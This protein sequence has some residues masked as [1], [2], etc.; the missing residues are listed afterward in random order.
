MPG[1][2]CGTRRWSRRG[3]RSGSVRATSSQ[4][5]SWP[6]AVGQHAEG[7]GPV[8]RVGLRGQGVDAGDAIGR[9]RRGGVAAARLLGVA[10]RA[11]CPAA[12]AGEQD[13]RGRRGRGRSRDRGR[14]PG[15]GPRPP[16]PRG[17]ATRRGPRP[18]SAGPTASGGRAPSA[19]SKSARA[20]CGSSGRRA[21]PRTTQLSAS[22]GVRRSPSARSRPA[23]S[24][25]PERARASARMK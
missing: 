15:R 18:C 3:S 24:R 21:R 7:A 16:P 13:A 9:V 20:P 8:G 5:P 10:M 1:A 19:A 4:R 6:S 12:E 23:P 14:R 25:S 2:G 22:A 11:S 17:R